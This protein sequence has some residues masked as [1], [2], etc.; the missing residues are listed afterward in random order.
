MNE[1]TSTALL[2]FAAGALLLLG[3][4]ASRISGRTGVPSALLFLAVGMLAGSQGLGGIAFEDYRLA[5]R[6]GTAAL[7][8]ILFDGGLNTPLELVRRWYRPAAVLATLG[9]VLTAAF[10]A[11][12]ARLLGFSW[13]QAALLGAVVS[14]TDAAAVFAA[15]RASGLQLKK[16]VGI[17]LELES[18]LNDP[19]AVIL[20]MAVTGFIVA[21]R[22]PGW[23]S[24]LQ[25]PVQIGVGVLAGI[26]VG[27]LG[28]TLLR[29]VRLTVGGLYPVMS[30]AL[31]LLAFSVPSLLQGSGFLAVYLAGVLL[32]SSP[33]LPYR[34]GLVRVHDAA[35]WL[36]QV[37]MFLLLGLL[38][39]PLELLDV[40]LP[41][42]G[43]ALLLAFV[44]RPLA[45]LLC[46]LPFRF[47]FREV[48]YVC[49][50]GLRGAVPIILGTFPVLAGVPGA[51]RLF[52]VVFFVVVV[53]SLLPGATLAWVTRRLGL[54]SKVPPPPT[55][56]LEITATRPL[57]TELMSFHIGVA[58]AVADARVA[59]I[60]FPAASAAMLIVRGDELIA[61]RGDTVL[62][63]GDHVYVFSRA[64]DRTFI[65]L[66]FG[67][68]EQ[69]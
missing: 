1:L 41:S 3:T 7:T 4:L 22:P 40:T 5:F 19:M 65:Q 11:L 57:G 20:T 16:R 18:G 53:N 14:S 24:L 63:S 28:R 34:S 25:I 35:A 49:W 48:V 2:L 43:L 39:F 23:G 51:E 44:A 9:V 61:P 66:L 52:N 33:D 59:E 64:E 68:P 62:K 17:T 30:I 55:T 38:V 54:E 27:L 13:A 8:L 37:G 32:G 58:S 10:V 6:M 21:G 26:G 60:P 31:A 46:L 36:S 67:R 29:H 12:G 47:P 45:V 69:D 15:L 42:I 50:V 56:S